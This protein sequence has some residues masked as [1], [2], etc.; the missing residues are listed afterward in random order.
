MREQRMWKNLILLLS[1]FDLYTKKLNNANLNIVVDM[2][3]LELNKNRMI[4][5]EERS[6]LDFDYSEKKIRL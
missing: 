3:S 5:E 2:P 6:I 1:L 4:T